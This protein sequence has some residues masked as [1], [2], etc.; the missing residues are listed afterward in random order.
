MSDKTNPDAPHTNPGTNKDEAAPDYPAMLSELNRYLSLRTPV[1]GMQRYRTLAEMEA[2]PK[3]RRPPHKMTLDQIVGQ[4]RLMGVTMGA[5]VEDLAGAQCAVPVGMM[6]RSKEWLAGEL[7]AGVWYE[8][9]ADSA[10]HQQEMDCAQDGPFEAIAVS[11]LASGKLGNPEICLVYATP[12]QM[13]LLINGLQYTG[14]KK[15][16]FTVV[17]ESAC[18]DSW[19]RAFRTGEP[20]LSLPCYA[21]RAFG[22]VAEDELLIA[23]PLGYLPKVIDGLGKLHRNG[24][25]YPIPPLGV[26][27][28]PMPTLNL[29]Y[30]GKF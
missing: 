2:V 29:S 16:T 10:A 13:I 28:D 26:R 30:D 14:Y 3:I 17:G 19:G 7:M 15:L 4:S 23:L 25:R 27:S 1:V 24:L 5:S 9:Q 18:A 11:P 8:T 21:E 20:S 12:A 22:G 6:P